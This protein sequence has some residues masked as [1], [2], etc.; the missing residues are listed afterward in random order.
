LR[1]STMRFISR[2]LTLLSMGT[3]PSEQNMFCSAHWLRT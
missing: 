2:S 1:L 3:A